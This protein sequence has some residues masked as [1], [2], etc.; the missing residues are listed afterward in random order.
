M[1]LSQQGRE[2]DQV[3][4][5]R[6]LGSAY[7]N[8]IRRGADGSLVLSAD[9]WRLEAVRADAFR[10]VARSAEAPPLV[11]P[12]AD[13]ERTTWDR[14]PRQQ[15]RSQIRFFLR[16]GDLW[17]FSGRVDEATLAPASPN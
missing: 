6:A 14:L 5:A 9:T 12:V 13:V 1:G 8:L 16:G 2:L 7:F 11:L 4:A 17:T 3:T 10:F 15:R